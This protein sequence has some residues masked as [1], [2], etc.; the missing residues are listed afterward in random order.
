MYL[1]RNFLIDFSFVDSHAIAGLFIMT[2]G[3]SM[4]VKLNLG[5]SPV[6]SIP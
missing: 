3:V 4:S 5:V 2:L 1:T 6:S